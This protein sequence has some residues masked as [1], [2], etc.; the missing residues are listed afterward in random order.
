MFY[1]DHNPNEN[2]ARCL[3]ILDLTRASISQTIRN[4]N[5]PTIC[6]LTRFAQH[7][8]MSGQRYLSAGSLWRLQ[9]EI[10][11]C[12]A[13]RHLFT[14]PHILEIKQLAIQQV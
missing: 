10:E 3:K 6:D 4:T 11:R 5:R 14:C 2:S 8:V 12:I 9:A 13:F 7:A 1:I